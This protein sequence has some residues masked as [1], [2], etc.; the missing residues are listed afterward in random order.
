VVLTHA[1]ARIFEFVK[2]GWGRRTTFRLDAATPLVTFLPLIR[3]GAPAMLGGGSSNPGVIAAT[4]VS[5]CVRGFHHHHSRIVIASTHRFSHG[6][7]L[8]DQKNGKEQTIVGTYSVRG[9]LFQFSHENAG[10]GAIHY[11]RQ[12]QLFKIGLPL[13]LA[14]FAITKQI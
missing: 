9:E 10:L 11:Q 13:A 7:R 5:Q 1:I 14:K 12:T 8:L 3:S 6:R 2:G 4:G